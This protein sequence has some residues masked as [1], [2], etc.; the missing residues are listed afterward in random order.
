MY[1]VYNVHSVQ[2]T[3]CTVQHWLCLIT[4]IARD[5]GEKLLLLNNQ[6][7]AFACL[8]S[9]NPL[10]TERRKKEQ[11]LYNCTMKKIVGQ[12]LFVWAQYWEIILQYG[13][14]VF[15]YYSAMFLELQLY[16][17]L[18]SVKFTEIYLL[19][20]NVKKKNVFSYFCFSRQNPSAGAKILPQKVL[21]FSSSKKLFLGHFSDVTR[22][23]MIY[24]GILRNLGSTTDQ[25]CSCNRQ[26]V[27]ITRR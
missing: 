23:S 19:F 15:V 20:F 27:G 5:I 21:P 7:K 26:P 24:F 9:F 2:C 22:H 6:H 4:N 18:V 13:I 8:G 1:T 11:E 12:H 14:Q 3:Q 17:V 16:R 10:L 25:G